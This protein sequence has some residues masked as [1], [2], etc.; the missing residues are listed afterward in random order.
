MLSR[1]RIFDHS[2]CD[3]RFQMKIFSWKLQNLWTDVGKVRHPHPFHFY[4]TRLLR[5]IL[6]ELNT[7]TGKISNPILFIFY[8]FWSWSTTWQ[9]IPFLHSVVGCFIKISKFLRTQIFLKINN[10]IQF[11]T[12]FRLIIKSELSEVYEKSYGFKKFA[13]KS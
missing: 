4:S 10:L 7:R 8:D 5:R 13:R 1:L 11:L 2:W 6:V 12:L 9:S 3:L